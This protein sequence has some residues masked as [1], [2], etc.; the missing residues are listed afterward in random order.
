[1]STKLV[2][3]SVDVD[4]KAWLKAMDPQ[5]QIFLDLLYDSSR[6]RLS[7]FEHPLIAR[8]PQAMCTSC[9]ARWPTQLLLFWHIIQDQLDEGLNVGTAHCLHMKVQLFP[10][11]VGQL[12]AKND[13]VGCFNSWARAAVWINSPFFV[14]SVC[15]GVKSVPEGQP[16]EDAASVGGCLVPDD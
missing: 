7:V 14:N 1:M 12:A 5:V 4:A 8:L 10:N 3:P 9:E 16:K 13:V 11:F 2:C 6:V 15:I